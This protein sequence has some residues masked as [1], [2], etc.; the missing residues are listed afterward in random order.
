MA[1]SPSLILVLCVPPSASSAARRG[2][3][4]TDAKGSES[5]R[6]GV[7]RSVS[8]SRW[9]VLSSDGASRELRCVP[10]GIGRC[11]GDELPS[12][13]RCRKLQ[14][15]LCVSLW[16]GRDCQRPEEARALSIPRLIAARVREDL[17]PVGATGLTIEPP[18]DLFRR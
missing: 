14:L 4:G 1:A 15:E 8:G 6:L 2:A 18:M 12:A 7:R 13:N 11:G 9:I 16:I 3:L 17:D 5:Q 10:R